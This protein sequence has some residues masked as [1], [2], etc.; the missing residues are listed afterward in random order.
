MAEIAYC[1]GI[2]DFRLYRLIALLLSIVKILPLLKGYGLW[3]MDYGLWIWIIDYGY[4][5]WIMDCG[6]WIVDCGLWI[7]DCGLWMDG[8]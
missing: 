6:L 7:V 4:G 8:F 2:V 1:L 3:I 5:L